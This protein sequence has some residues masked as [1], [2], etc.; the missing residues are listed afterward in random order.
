MSHYLRLKTVTQLQNET[1]T[2]K[3]KIMPTISFIMLYHLQDVKLSQ[4]Y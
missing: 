2:H 4:N 1:P 3:Y